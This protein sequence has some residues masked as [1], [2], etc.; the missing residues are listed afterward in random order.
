MLP[1]QSSCQ[2]S[3]W[4]MS[5][6]ETELRSR[7]WQQDI[8]KDEKEAW[9]TPYWRRGTALESSRSP[10]EDLHLRAPT[11]TA[12]GEASHLWFPVW[13]LSPTHSTSAIKAILPFLWQ[14]DS[15][16]HVTKSQSA[17]PA[18]TE[19]RTVPLR[20]LGRA[21]WRLRAQPC[22]HGLGSWTNQGTALHS[23]L[24]LPQPE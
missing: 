12:P 9:N 23:S 17:E 10:R 15:L 6:G 24:H 11:L 8:N 4:G 7:R 2:T 1:V 5:E 16:S 22:G 14:K 19:P 13:S 20:W 21:G 3:P 18:D